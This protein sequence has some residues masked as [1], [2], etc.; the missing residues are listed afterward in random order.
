MPKSNSW[1]ALAKRREKRLKA[2][3]QRILD[4]FVDVIDAMTISHM[5]DKN[6]SK[7]LS[8]GILGFLDFKSATAFSQTCSF[9][10]TH[11][12]QSGTLNQP[13]HIKDWV[14]MHA[15]HFESRER[16]LGIPNIWSRISECQNCGCN[17][18][19]DVVGDRRCF[20]QTCKDGCS[21]VKV[22]SFMARMK[23]ISKKVEQYRNFN[24]GYKIGYYDSDN[25]TVLDSEWD[26]DWV[27]DF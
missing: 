14:E 10:R 19:C 20:C 17:A 15:Q 21:M 23:K 1:S 8:G 26:S 3:K 11:V 25:N 16:K 4:K 27:K 5:Y 6:V 18:H 9:F 13:Y 12:L 24:Y 22:E 2:A 7:T